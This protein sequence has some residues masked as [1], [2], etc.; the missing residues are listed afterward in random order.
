MYIS[1]CIISP[2]PNAH[3]HAPR[4]LRRLAAPCF[5]QPSPGASDAK[6]AREVRANCRRRGHQAG[7]GGEGSAGQRGAGGEGGA[8]GGAEG[9]SEGAA[10]EGEGAAGG[11]VEG[12][13]EGAAGDG[14]GAGGE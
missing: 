6:P 4:A 13:S 9:A 5:L 12:G 11:G 10:G 8:G 3:V 14:E 7:A 2:Y 1:M